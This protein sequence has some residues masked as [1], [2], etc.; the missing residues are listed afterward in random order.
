MPISETIVAARSSERSR[1]S[2][3]TRCNSAARSATEVSRPHA[4]AAWAA[5]SAS[6]TSASVAWAKVESTSPVRGSVTA[7]VAGVT[8]GPV[9]TAEVDADVDTGAGVVASGDVPA[10]REVHSSITAASVGRVSRLT[11]T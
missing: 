9:P 2:S 1:W 6:D 4:V 11:T 7:N 10:S 5:A 3:A 8:G